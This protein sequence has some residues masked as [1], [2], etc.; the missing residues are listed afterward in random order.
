MITGNTL[1]F[2][3][4]IENIELSALIN[5]ADI[6]CIIDNFYRF[7]KI[8]MAII[9][10]NGNILVKTGWQ[11]ICVE[12]HRK[13]PDTCRNCI[14]SDMHLT[15]GIPRGEFK[16]YKCRNGMWDM[17][18]P[19]F[20]GPRKI[21][22]L[23]IGQFFFEGETID[24]NYFKLQAE[25]YNFNRTE[26]L[27][28]LEKVPFLSKEDLVSAKI[29]LTKLADSFS[30]LS[31]TNIKLEES[32]VRLERTQ[33]IAHLGSWELDVVNNHLS[34]S[35]E[36]YRIFGFPSGISITYVD[37]LNTVH[38]DDRNLVAG[39]YSGSIENQNDRYEIEHRIIR[40]NTGELRFVHEKCQHN[41]DE[42]GKIVSSIGMVL[43]IT[44]RKNAEKELLDHK[45]KLNLALEKG[46]IGL[47]EWDLKTDELI[48]DERM[49][50]MFG[51]KPG[52]FGKTYQAF[53]SL[54]HEEDVSR[55]R[56]TVNKT[57]NKNILGETIFRSKS[58]KGITKFISFKPFVNKDHKGN[59]ENM[60]GVCF[61]VTGLQEGT[62]KLVLKLNEELL[63]S[64][65]E[66]ERFA[67]VASHDLQEP[68]RMVTSFTQLLSMQ[69]GDQLDARARDYINYAVDGTKRMYE[70]LNG[71]LTYSRIQTK[72]RSFN[73]VDLAK[74]LEIT[75]R[76]L[77]LKIEESKAEIQSEELPVVVADEIQ[78]VQLF[79]NLIANSI[80]FS[81]GIPRIFIESKEEKNKVIIT[82]RD[83]GIGIEPQYFEKIF[84]IFQ[85]LMPRDKYEG[86]GIGLAV[87][88]RIV[89]R[90]GGNIWL[91][92]E[93]GKGSTFRFT[94]PTNK[95]HQNFHSRN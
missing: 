71:L 61:D 73:N 56:K 51:I 63:R 83:E 32:K 60:I 59:P 5:V 39:A 44:E 68:L 62:E 66:L 70:L 91:E 74:V 21:G 2:A 43:D 48:L 9:D 76:N 58:K 42:S 53:E 12:F 95:L 50:K 89:E 6:Q 86:T 27:N 88:K 52:S 34:W 36:V 19:L 8:P 4:D 25:L 85:R 26:Y 18:T 10:C 49:E 87:C 13:N 37:F 82:V 78:M 3:Q 41:R 7:S 20:I 47:W 40:K 90:H 30:Q 28:A 16:L 75:L 54:I 15:D 65:Q 46:K 35:E 22:N 33:A 45:I 1:P 92:S 29:F 79:Q 14:E 94:I 55:V 80:K 17:A 64:N 77:A 23:F 31:Y 67:Y 11:R 93:P 24:Y 72:G 84:Q 57:L 81:T 38:P 69:Y